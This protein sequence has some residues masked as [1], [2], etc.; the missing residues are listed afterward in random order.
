LSRLASG[1]GLSFHRPEQDWREAF[2]KYFPDIFEA[3]LRYRLELL[4][5]G[6][7]HE[8]IWPEAYG[9]FDLLEM[10]IHGAALPIPLQVL[11][12][13]FFGVKV[14]PH[15]SSRGMRAYPVMKAMVKVKKPYG[16]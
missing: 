16:T 1:Y 4:A 8:Y 11:W 9:E 6:Y 5:T 15:G 14:E 7:E 2:D 3:I 10:G 13:V 12:T